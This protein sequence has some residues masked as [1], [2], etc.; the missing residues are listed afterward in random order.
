MTVEDF[1]YASAV[2]YWQ[3]FFVAVLVVIGIRELTK[4]AISLHR[5][6][7]QRQ[8]EREEVAS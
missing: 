3:G 6:A 5:Y 4:A 1:A 8:A 7:K 2:G